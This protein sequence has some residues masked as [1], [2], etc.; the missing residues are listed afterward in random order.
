MIWNYYE[1][2]EIQLNLFETLKDQLTLTQCVSF[3]HPNKGQFRFSW[4]TAVQG[5][6]LV[7][8]RPRRHH[9]TSCEGVH[10]KGDPH[11][12]WYTPATLPEDRR[13]GSRLISLQPGSGPSDT[14][15]ASGE[16]PG[17]SMNGGLPGRGLAPGERSGVCGQQFTARVL[18]TMKGGLLSPHRPG[19]QPNWGA[20]LSFLT[21]SM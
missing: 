7:Y 5:R 17:W 4:G 20:C 3:Q 14:G 10:S 2:T 8:S 12:G 13:G 11:A 18:P 21:R 9:G 6:L 19:T 1:F 15:F 16:T